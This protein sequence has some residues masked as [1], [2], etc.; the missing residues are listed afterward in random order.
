[1]ALIYTPLSA[2]T[3]GGHKT[4][5]PDSEEKSM[6]KRLVRMA[7]EMAKKMRMNKMS[8]EMEMEEEE[9][10]EELWHGGEVGMDDETFM[11][12]PY[13][14][15]AEEM[16]QES[17]GPTGPSLREATGE[18]SQDMDRKKFLAMFLARKA[19]SARR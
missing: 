11:N 1:M 7:Y 13:P 19:R 12:M 14:A 9:S 2:T 10:P 18:A 8:P 17:K 16:D 5:V 15:D 3:W 4:P 6:E